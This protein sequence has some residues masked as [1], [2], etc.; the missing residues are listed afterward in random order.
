MTACPKCHGDGHYESHTPGF[1]GVPERDDE[2]TCSECFG[3]GYMEAAEMLTL[4]IG[5]RQADN[6]ARALGEPGL[7]LA[8]PWRARMAKVIATVADYSTERFAELRAK[9]MAQEVTR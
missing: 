7:C 2:V 9:E 8:T 5:I 6:M 4:I 3:L 1:E